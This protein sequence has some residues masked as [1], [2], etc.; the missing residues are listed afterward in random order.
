MLKKLMVTVIAAGALSVPL[1]GVAWGDPPTDPGANG[2]G[3]G[4]GGIP[5]V[6]GDNSGGADPIPPGSVLSDIAP[7]TGS[8]CPRSH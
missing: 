4:A 2:D 5:R 6:L 3:V 8:F 7:A 1:A